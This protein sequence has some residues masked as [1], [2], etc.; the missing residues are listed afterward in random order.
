MF[1]DLPPLSLIA[2]DHGGKNANWIYLMLATVGSA[3]GNR[4]MR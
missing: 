4:Y 3:G 2:L 1:S